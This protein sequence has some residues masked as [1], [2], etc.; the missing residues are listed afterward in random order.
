MVSA[1]RGLPIS[2]FYA[3]LWEKNKRLLFSTLF[4]NYMFPALLE[5][6]PYPSISRYYHDAS[7][8]LLRSCV[9]ST[10]FI[11]LLYDRHSHAVRPLA[12]PHHDQSLSI[13]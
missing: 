7:L 10:A 11:A 6:M 12:F 5:F 9:L 4:A 13:P 3:Y 8:V 2:E 1:V